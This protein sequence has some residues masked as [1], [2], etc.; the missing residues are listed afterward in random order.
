MCV[1]CVFYISN[2]IHTCKSFTFH[3]L[4]FLISATCLLYKTTR[5]IYRMHSLYTQLVVLLWITCISCVH[6]FSLKTSHNKAVWYSI[7]CFGFSYA[8]MVL[9]Y[10][11][12]CASVCP[13][14]PAFG[15]YGHLFCMKTVAK[16]IVGLGLLWV[17]IAHNRWCWH[18]LPSVS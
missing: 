5:L 14:K 2:N 13:S 9:C 16:L 1:Y 17:Y 18:I 7:C 8:R 4:T 12:S 6:L 11:T 3:W 15:T 10:D